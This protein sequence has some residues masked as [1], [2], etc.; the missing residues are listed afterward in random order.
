MLPDLVVEA[1]WSIS[2]LRN[3]TID[4]DDIKIEEKLGNPS[5]TTLIRGTVIDKTFAAS[6]MVKQIENAKILL[7]N[8]ELDRSRTRTNS[9]L[10]ISSCGQLEKYYKSEYELLEIKVQNIIESGANIVISQKGINKI[11][12]QRLSRADILTLHRVKENDMLWLERSTGAKVVKDLN[13]PI[14]SNNLGY[15]GKVYE[16]LVGDDKM[17]FIDECKNPKSVTLLL[18]ANSKRVLDEYHRSALDGFA[19][20]RDYILSPRIVGGA[21]ATEMKVA[22]IIRDRSRLIKGRVQLVLQKFAEALEEIPT[23]LARNAGMDTVNTIVQLRS[24]HLPANSK[25]RWYGIDSKSRKVENIISSV[26]EPSIVKEQVLKTA[27]EVTCMLLRVDDVLMAKPKMQTHT[28]ADG[29]EHSHPGG[30][31]KHDHY[32][33]RLGKQQR[34]MH[35]YY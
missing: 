19:V 6:T 18:R 17:V 9:E 13:G 25:I 7:T 10:N 28:H 30:D 2:D 8:E 20:L 1:V 27:V 23:T 16:K 12:Q 14:P 24:K 22:A 21:G 15:A 11:V 4:I 34:P 33:D 3:K 32:F 29:V 5:D 35:H 31:K 26:I